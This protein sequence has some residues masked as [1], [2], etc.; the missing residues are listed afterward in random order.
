MGIQPVPE[1][2]RVDREG[3]KKVAGDLHP[4]GRIGH[5]LHPMPLWKRTFWAVWT[6]NLITSIGMMCFLPYFAQHIEEL[7]VEDEGAIK[8]W[9]GVVFGAAPMVAALIGPLWG[10]L[11]DRYGRRPMVLRAQVA[12]FLFVG[13]MAFARSPWELLALRIGQGLFSGWIAPSLALVSA[14]TPED[15][16][17]RV[18][19]GLQS[20]LAAGSVLGPLLGA[21]LGAHFGA[22]NVYLFVSMA[23]A[24]S[25][26]LILFLTQ[27]DA[28][29]RRSFD[30][31][32]RPQNLLR[33][34]FSDV[35]RF[36]SPGPLRFALAMVFTAYL[37]I[38]A[39]IPQLQLFVEELLPPLAAGED[40]EAWDA[41]SRQLT[42]ILFAANAG[43]LLVA[44][45]LWGRIS[46]RIGAGR[47]L[48]ICTLTTSGVLA[49]HA[50]VPGYPALLGAFVLLAIASAGAGP[51]SY[52]VAAAETSAEERGSVF[53]VVFSARAF[54]RSL[55]GMVGGF[56][57]ALL[58]IRGLFL[59][60]ALLA[61][62]PL[63]AVV[64]TR[65]RRPGPESAT[66]GTGGNPNL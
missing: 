39:V 56:A 51:S 41:R 15:R 54:S 4:R 38:G 12:V 28:P 14:I 48:W 33:Q 2:S 5:S 6:A 22:R 57:A 21:Q 66:P 20:A 42:S 7:G 62:L 29:G 35:R 23:A 25:G 61:A 63:L 19:G 3:S 64:R 37:G 34:S 40:P 18:Q 44:G 27:E 50:F 55:A 32:E 26:L 58:G 9:T 36:L 8:V 45:P 11:G 65:L 59:L 13:A 43:C 1:P 16:Q 30:A 47:S 24:L 10:T 52:G 17:G 31:Q 49:L 53:A 46:D 60:G